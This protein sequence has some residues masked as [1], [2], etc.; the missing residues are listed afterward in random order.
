MNKAETYDPIWADL[1]DL[2]QGSGATGPRSSDPTHQAEQER[3]RWQAVIDD[4]LDKW[5]RDPSQLEDDGIIAPTVKTVELASQLARELTDA[6]V[7]GPQR[8]AATGDGGIIFVR[9]TGSFLS[10][11][12][13]DAEGS[14]ELVV[15]RDSR[16]VSRQQLR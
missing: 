15:F 2:L 14:I 6:G 8:V 13:I 9:Q 10:T 16:L 12:E 1:R 3:K 4:S 7:P 5:S 11:L